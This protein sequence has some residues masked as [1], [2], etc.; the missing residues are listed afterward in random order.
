MEN[1][2][3]V[4]VKRFLRLKIETNETP[5][6]EKITRSRKK[7]VFEEPYINQPNIEE[8]IIEELKK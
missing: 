3:K 8:P 2:P 6:I 7:V 5:T 1:K 4:N